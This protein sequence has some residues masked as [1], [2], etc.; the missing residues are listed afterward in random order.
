MGLNSVHSVEV[1]F[2][3]KFI[4]RGNK[5]FAKQMVKQAQCDQTGNL[6]RPKGRITATRRASKRDQP[7]GIADSARANATKWAAG[8]DLKVEK[9]SLLALVAVE[10]GKN[11]MRLS[12]RYD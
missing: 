11:V 6:K 7:G 8:L 2:L 9:R 12:A 1:Q 10:R 3:F 5:K 4:F